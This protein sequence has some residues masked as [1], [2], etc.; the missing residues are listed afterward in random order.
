MTV[1]ELIDNLK[2]LPPYYKVLVLSDARCDSAKPSFADLDYLEAND[3]DEDWT[4]ESVWILSS[5][6]KHCNETV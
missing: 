1:Q 5:K 6:R 2:T 4:T 3:V